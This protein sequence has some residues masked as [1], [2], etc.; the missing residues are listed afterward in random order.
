MLELLKYF[1]NC[2]KNKDLKYLGRD[3]KK[4]III[5]NIAENFQNQPENGIFI[6]S[7]FDDMEDKTLSEL[8]PLLKGFAWKINKKIEIVTTNVSDVRVALRLYRDRVIRKITS[9]GKSVS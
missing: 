5:D 8:A 3:L 9:I 6:K 7:F 1:S 4:I 2:D